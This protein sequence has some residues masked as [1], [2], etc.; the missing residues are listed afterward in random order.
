MLIFT[1]KKAKT[2]RAIIGTCDY[3]ALLFVVL[4]RAQYDLMS[5]EVLSF[6]Y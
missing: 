5:F 4:G 3:E 6:T 2:V 1:G